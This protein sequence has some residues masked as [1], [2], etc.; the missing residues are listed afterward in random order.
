ME[1]S[2]PR[3]FVEIVAKKKGCMLCDLAVAILEEIAGEFEEGVL[4]WEIVDMGDREG[5]RRHE[6]LTRLCGAKPAVPSIVINEKIAFDHIPE[7]E[8]LT[9]AVKRASGS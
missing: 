6:A 2:G 3:V 4:V 1:S 5:L 8:A 7:M 9:Q